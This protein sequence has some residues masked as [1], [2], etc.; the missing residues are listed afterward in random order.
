VNY[1]RTTFAVTYRDSTNLDFKVKRNGTRLIHPRPVGWMQNLSGDI[2]VETD[3]L[4]S[5]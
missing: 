3:I 5:E 2:R 4:C 1:T